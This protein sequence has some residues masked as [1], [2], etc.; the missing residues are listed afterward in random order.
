MSAESAPISLSRFAAALHDLP[1]SALYAKHAELTNS[2][3]H[4]ESSNQQLADFAREHDDRDC[5]E[6]L[7]ENRQVVKNMRERVDAVR[8]EVEIVRGLLWMPGDEVLKREEEGAAPGLVGQVNGGR[9]VQTN[10]DT[11]AQANGD[12]A[13]QANGVVEP[14]PGREGAGAQEGAAAQGGDGEEGVYL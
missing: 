7:L 12:R 13:A 6:A 8:S 10:G 4:L 2:L 5:Y 11:A 3:A 14:A 1:I 9:A